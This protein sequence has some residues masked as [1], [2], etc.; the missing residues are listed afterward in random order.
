MDLP[1][2]SGDSTEWK[3]FY[4]AFSALV[5]TNIAL[6]ESQKLHYLR[7][8]LKG[9]ALKIVNGFKICDANYSEEWDLLK[10]RYKVLRVIV[11]VHFR[12]MAEIRKASNDTAEAIKTVFDAFQQHIRELKAIG[13]PVE[14]WDDWL[15]HEIVSRLAFE[16][17]KQWELSLLN[18]DPPTFEQLSTFLEIR[19]RSLSMLPTPTTSSAAPTKLA[20]VFHTLSDTNVICCIYC[21]G[22]HKI[23]SCEKFRILD[24]NAKSSFVKESKACINCLSTGHYKAQCNSTSVCR[25][26]Q[27]RH[28]T[29]L[30]VNANAANVSPTYLVNEVKEPSSESSPAN[31]S[32][33]FTSSTGTEPLCISSCLNSSPSPTTQ[34]TVL[35]STALVKI[36]D[37]TGK[38]QPARLLFDSGSH[39]SFVTESCVQRLG[40]SRSPSTVFIT[41]IGSSQGGK[42]R[43]ETLISLSPYYS[44]ECYTINTLILSNITGELPTHALAV[45][46]WSHV[47]DLLLADPQFM[48]P[49]RVD[50]LIGMDVMEQFLCSGLRKGL[51]GTPMAQKTVFHWLFGSISAE[52]SPTSRFQS[53]HCDVHLE[54]ALAKLWELEEAPQK[55]HLTSEEQFCEDHFRS[56]HRRDLSGRFIVELPLKSEIALGSSRN[57]AIRSLL[58]IEKKLALNKD[59]RSRYN[60]FMD[61][62][63]EMNHMEPASEVTSAAYY[64]P[65]HPVIKESS[66]TTKLRVVFNAS[67]RTTSGKSL[68]DALCVGPQLQQN[69]F[70]ILTRFRTHRYAVTADIAKMYRQ[71]LLSPKH[72]DL[73]RIVWRRDSSLPIM[74]YRMLRVTYGVA[75]ASYLAVKS[76]QQ[77]AKCSTNKSKKAAAV[78][79]KDFYMDDLLTGT[80]TDDEL[81]LLQQN[82]SDILKE[83]GFELRKWATNCAKLNEYISRNAPNISHYLID[84]KDVYAL[85]LVWN[86]ADDHFTFAINLK[87]R[88]AT[89]TKRAFLSDVSTLFDP[90]G[91]LA[92]VTIRSKI[93][94]QEIWR[95]GVDWDDLV[96][97]DISAQWLEHRSGL[98]QLTKLKV[99]RWL[100]SGV[101]GSIIELHIFADASER[102]YAATLYARTTQNDGR[103]TVLLIASKTKVAP[104]KP[105]TLPRLELCA[106]HLAAKLVR[107]VLKSWTDISC[108]LYAW[109]DSTITLAWLQSHPSRW[110]TFIAN[111][112]ANVHEILPPQC[113]NHV[114]SEQNPADCASRGI[115]PS[116]LLNHPLWWTGPTFLKN[117]CCFW[118]QSSEKIH[119]TEIGAKGKVRAH[120][121]NSN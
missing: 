6:S 106:A 3:G 79:E 61:E 51:P 49:G 20:K 15:V 120:V 18:D 100:G 54:R 45:S 55:M 101:D 21:N 93:W 41:G 59:L 113:W 40:L 82:I 91:L 36:R 76:L 4:D 99:N 65:H 108:P 73:Q 83:G 111:R 69:L 44:D 1:T 89:L 2:F 117:T 92:P 28:H 121:V 7:S 107:I 5:D 37:C 95:S 77:T 43:G 66:I 53:L 52:E 11:E 12:A 84:D 25:I 46:S 10:S 38:W 33:G 19:C 16:T 68:N 118:R 115:K 98:L 72:V 56:S 60:E 71:V 70:S 96:P 63:T 90:L 114:R 80:S 62:L 9:D 75:S 39:A 26:C 74:D 27:K 102:A 86:T 34:R 112:V 32:S 67:A 88:P 81:L 94:F 104:L 64:M 17:R 13:R 8:C 50:L 119:T 85:G 29:L 24:S 31:L 116:E 110:V 97:D 42:S 105:T 48:K 78:I 14:F 22:S 103:V 109:T 23:Y 47:N 58:Q 30:H 57:F 35:L 87:E